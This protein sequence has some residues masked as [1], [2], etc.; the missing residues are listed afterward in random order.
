LLRT[1]FIA[2]GCLQC[3]TKCVIQKHRFAEASLES[4]II[5][6]NSVKTKKTT[7]TRREIKQNILVSVVC[8]L[9]TWKHK[10]NF[11]HK[12]T[13]K[14]KK[15]LN[16]LDLLMLTSGRIYCG[17]ECD[18]ATYLPVKCCQFVVQENVVKKM[19]CYVIPITFEVSLWVL[20]FLI[21]FSQQRLTAYECSNAHTTVRNHSKTQLILNFY[22]KM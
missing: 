16:Y 10:K 9:N 20:W 8:A 22:A 11:E 4:P 12:K 7:L 13:K 19:M 5:L 15:K 21:V 14:L 17:Q 3:T 6:S 1:R 18:A 2:T